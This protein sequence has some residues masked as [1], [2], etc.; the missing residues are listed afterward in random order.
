[1]LRDAATPE[2]KQRL[3]DQTDEALRLGA[4][5]VPTIVVDGELFWG[6]DALPDVDVFL[7][8]EDPVDGA[9]VERWATLPASATRR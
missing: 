5:G 4:F 8:G 7:R 6:L 1:M 3:R 9:A 2:V